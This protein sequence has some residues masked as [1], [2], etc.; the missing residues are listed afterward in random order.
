MA[1]QPRC[2]AVWGR[3]GD[4]NL[5][6]EKEGGRRWFVFSL[7]WLLAKGVFLCPLA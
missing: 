3:L 1:N 7:P 2:L 4:S 6:E 5:Q